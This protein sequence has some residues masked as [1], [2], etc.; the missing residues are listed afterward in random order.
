MLSAIWL[1]R[2]INTELG[3]AFVAPWDVYE[4]PGEW[5]DAITGMSVSL[6]KMAAGKEQVEDYLA[7][8]RQKHKYK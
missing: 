6:P 5:L 2:Q 1:A 4:L 3:G 7:K 8:W